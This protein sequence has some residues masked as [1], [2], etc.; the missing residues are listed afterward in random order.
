MAVYVDNM[1]RYAWMD[2]GSG[3]PVTGRWSHLLADDPAELAA[4]AARLGLRPEWLQLPG[5]AREHYDVVET[6]RRRAVKAGAVPI[7]YPRGTANLIITKRLQTSALDAASRDWQV[8]PLQPGSKIPAVRDWRQQA[9]TDP[10]RIGRWWTVRLH[11]DR[12]HVREPLNLAIAC[13][14]SALVV[15][16]LDLAKPDHDSAVAPGEWQR[17]SITSG[18]EVLAA[19]A[20]QVGDAVPE[21]YTVATASGG[22]HLY[23]TAPDGVDVRNSAGRVGPT[24]DV[25]GEGGYVVAAGS[26]IRDRA[27]RDGSATDM[28]LRGYRLLDPRPPVRLPSWLTAAV[29]ATRRQDDGWAP[30]RRP[31]VAGQK[32]AVENSSDGY[33]AAAL[34]GEVARVRSAPVGRRNHTLNAAA[35]SLGQLV[36]AGVLDQ[37]RT[38]EALRFAAD[39]AGLETDEIAATIDSGLTAGA[40]RPRIVSPR[41]SIAHE[42]DPVPSG[43]VSRHEPDA[44]RSADQV[45]PTAAR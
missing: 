19:L 31:L 28:R 29:C 40:R 36:A 35:Y 44:S 33:G 43:A 12:R 25:R 20:D 13:G 21:T 23:F 16:D 37:N 11:R 38:V 14:A 18:L 2:R 32:H 22:R 10:D 30:D 4:F 26:R 6:V 8:F 15:I 9:T 42:T 24:I 17:G 39:S 34:R 3:R 7:A 41:R 27:G 45:E 5:T 1:R